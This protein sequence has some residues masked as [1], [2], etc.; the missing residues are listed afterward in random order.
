MLW[1]SGQIFGSSP[2]QPAPGRQQRYGLQHIGL[3][4]AIRPENRNGPAVKC[5]AR[6]AV[7]AKVRKLQRCDRKAA[8]TGTPF[9][10]S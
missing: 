3:A 6:Q 8:H 4:C 9:I 2:P 7:T 1:F 10:C 5:H